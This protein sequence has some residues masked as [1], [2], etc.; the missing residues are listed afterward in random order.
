MKKGFTILEM[1]GVII[2][3]SLMVILVFP[4][5]INTIKNKQSEID[6]VSMEILK[7][8]SNLYIQN[9][10]KNYAKIDDNKYCITVDE[11]INSGYLKDSFKY[12]GEDVKDT[13]QIQVT[14]NSGYEYDLVDIDEC[15]IY[16]PFCEAVD[17]D[18]E[19]DIYNSGDKFI[20]EVESG[21]KYNFYLLNKADETI[22]LILNGN[23]YYDELTGESS[24]ASSSNK[25]LVAWQES[26]ENV[27]GPVTALD[28]LYNATK[29]WNNVPNIQVNYNDETNNSGVYGYGYVLTTGTETKITKREKTVVKSYDN[30]K[31][32]LPLKMEITEGN[33]LYDNLDISGGI[34]YTNNINGVFGYWLMDSV[35]TSNTIA[36]YVYCTGSIQNSTINYNNYYGVRP[37]ISITK[38]YIYK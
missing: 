38:E 6:S 14:Y 20:C 31:A 26:G 21:K 1:L 36:K 30:L 5:M 7:Q 37:V 9:N 15:T 3:I 32:R 23:I 29:D 4:N 34:T 12:N 24:L 27:S 25:G 2:L 17:S 33:W 16:A 28:Y 8:A 10:Q 22:N 18:I 13:K 11:L 35:A 19:N